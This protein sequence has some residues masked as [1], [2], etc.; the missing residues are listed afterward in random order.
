[1]RLLQKTNIHFNYSVKAIVLLFL[2]FFSLS[3]FAQRPHKKKHPKHTQNVKNT[4]ENQNKQHTGL[5][6]YYSD[7]FVGKKTANGDIFSQ[8]KMTAACNVLPLG[9]RVRVTN[10]KNG[11]SIIVRTNDRLHHKTK[12]VID[13]TKLAAEKLGILKSGIAKVTIEPIEKDT[14]E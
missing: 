6:S 11:K 14:T 1:M 13:L 12:R 10:I 4:F 7:K 2:M 8:K 5:A 3:I 9:T